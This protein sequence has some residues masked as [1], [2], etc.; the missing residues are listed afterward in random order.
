MATHSLAWACGASFHF[1]KLASALLARDFDAA[2]VACTINEWSGSVHNTGVIPRNVANRLLY[3]NA[4]RVIDYR[5][6]PDV[7][8]WVHDLSVADAPTLPAIE[9]PLSEPTIH[10][11]PSV[12][13]GNE[14]PDDVA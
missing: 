7:L 13:L 6:D 4:Q 12:Y 2:S 8:D 10:V 14:P 11:S 3:R 1:P 5:L 9:D